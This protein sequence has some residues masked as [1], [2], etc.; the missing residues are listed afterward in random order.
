MLTRVR[1]P[2]LPQIWD[3]FIEPSGQQYLVMEFVEGADLRTLVQQRGAL[4]EMQA[5]DWANQILDALEYLHTQN[6]PI[7]HRDIKPQNII[8]TPQNRAMLVDF[9]IAKMFYA[10]QA[11]T[12]G[13]R[14]VSSGYSPPEQ[15][16]QGTTDA[17]SDIYAMGATVYFVLTGGEPPESVGRYAG[18]TLVA[19]R[20]RNPSVSLPVE[21]TVLRALQLSAVNRPQTAQQMRAELRAPSA[22]SYAPYSPATT[23]G[24]SN[25]ALPPVSPSPLMAPAQ[26]ALS[27]IGA[28]TPRAS[29]TYLIAPIVV[30]NILGIV[31][32]VVMIVI[33]LF[34]GVLGTATSTDPTY[35]SVA[36][37]ALGS[38]LLLVCGMFL[39]VPFLVAMFTARG[40]RRAN[41]GGQTFGEALGDGV[42]AGVLCLTW[43]W[44]CA[45]ASV[46]LTPLTSGSTTSALTSLVYLIVLPIVAA[47]AGAVG[48]FIYRA[49]TGA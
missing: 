44:L 37:A 41:R 5:L 18:D 32:L 29:R 24:V 22:Q 17:R 26:T 4:A 34:V 21:G 8:I 15:Y 19:P 47:I 45:C 39:A 16:G 20:V 33:A 10:G 2:S 13:A 30:G 7:I 46:V 12:M 11:T 9:G 42:I 35:L 6:P 27:S 31:A 38:M 25:R 28:T 14:A 40:H 36:I 49:F 3:Y 48:G 43:Y 23:S 1:H